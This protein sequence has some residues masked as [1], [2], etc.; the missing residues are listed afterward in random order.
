MNQTPNKSRAVVLMSG[1]MDSCVTAAIARQSYEIAALHASYGQRTESREIQSF[2]ALADHFVAFTRLAVKLD[3]FRAIGGSSLTDSSMVIRKADLSSNEIPNTYVPF[4][5]AHFLSIATSW[6]EVLGA[7]RIFIGAVWEDSSGYPDC[8]PEYYEA[9]NR[10][11]RLGTRPSSD[12]SIETPLIRLSKH[13]IVR[14]GITLGAPFHLTWSCYRDSDVA[15]GV[16]DSCA[17]RL[18]AF[19][20]AGIDDPI[21]YSNRPE[22]ART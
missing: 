22:Y 16:C 2:Q 6:A 13:E 15:C 5:N 4:R 17:L 9:F 7:T 14:K 19:Q 3:H 21:P 10:V 8:R 20:E 11:I 12:V 1:G 18:R